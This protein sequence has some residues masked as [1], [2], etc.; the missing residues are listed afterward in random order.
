VGILLGFIDRLKALPPINELFDQCPS[1]NGVDRDAGKFLQASRRLHI[2]N[3]PA[4]V[5][6]SSLKAKGPSGARRTMRTSL[7]SG[8]Y[9]TFV[10]RTRLI[11]FDAAGRL[12]LGYLS[13]HT[14]NNFDIMQD[15][16]NAFEAREYPA[17]KVL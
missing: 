8:I 15:D 7:N 12:D 1:R 10:T 5:Q 17:G 4:D 11:N 9:S 13:N 16:C 3:A 6:S 14:R 2:G